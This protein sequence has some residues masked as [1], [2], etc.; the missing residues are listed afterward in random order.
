MKF[1]WIENNQVRDICP[2]N[3]QEL[4]TAEIAAL[5][6]TG[7]GD[8]VQRDAKL[9]NGVWM[10]PP[11]V[12]PLPPML[13]PRTWSAAQV[14]SKLTLAERVKWDND[15]SDA[16]KTAKIEFAGHPEEAH[17]REVLQ[18]LV[19]SGDISTSTMQAILA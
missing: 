9:V 14:R 2:G 8:D 16:I 11:E 5:Y 3:P 15:K 18:L 4:Y 1:A 6:T 19:D 7:I 17:T 10:N 13:D 12:E